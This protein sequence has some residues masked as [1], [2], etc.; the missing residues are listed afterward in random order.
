MQNNKIAAVGALF[1]LIGIIL[2]AFGAHALKELI[3]PEKLS[4]FETGVR[5]EIYHGLAI[6]LIGLN[7]KKFAFKSNWA[8]ALMVVGVI[9]F[10][11][12]IY[13]LALSEIIGVELSFLGP[14]TPIGGTLMIIAWIIIVLRL[15]SHRQELE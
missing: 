11:G 9:L 3:T 1:I 6:F 5:Y 15:L 13:F 8:I 2:G 10:S 12:S 7:Y 14:V 4:S